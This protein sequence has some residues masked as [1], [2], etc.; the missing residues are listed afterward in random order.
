MQ[1]E[2]TMSLDDALDIVLLVGIEQWRF[3]S[4]QQTLKEALD[5]V[6]RWQGSRERAN[7]YEVALLEAWLARSPV[8]PLQ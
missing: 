7:P 1:E 3:D 8:G 2:N 6:C 4:R 5:I